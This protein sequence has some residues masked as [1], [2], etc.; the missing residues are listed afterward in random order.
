[1][2]VSCGK[3]VERDLEAL[4]MDDNIGKLVE[5]SQVFCFTLSQSIHLGVQL[6]CMNSW[7]CRE[8]TWSVSEAIYY[9]LSDVSENGPVKRAASCS[10][11]AQKV[12]K[13]HILLNISH[14][15]AELKV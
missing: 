2:G 6:K 13:S 10:E 11:R 15:V 8:W 4:E 12:T 1:M 9:K 7:I 14:N 3:L 5:D